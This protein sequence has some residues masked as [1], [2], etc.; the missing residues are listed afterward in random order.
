MNLPS[1]INSGRRRR[2]R[3]SAT[4][5]SRG[6]LL[7]LLLPVGVLGQVPVLPPPLPLFLPLLGHFG[8]MLDDSDD[9]VVDVVQLFLGSNRRLDVLGNFD[10]KLRLVDDCELSVN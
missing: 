4:V 7:L 9:V 10:L 2:S 1:L 6:L 3:S 5:S 8:P